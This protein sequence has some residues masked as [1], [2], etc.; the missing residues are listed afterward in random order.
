MR[1]GLHGTLASQRIDLDAL[2]L[3]AAPAATQAGPAPAPPA[4]DGRVIP[5]L[6]LPLELL[7]VTDSELHWTIGA[8]QTGGVTL[9]DTTLQAEIRDGKG[10]LDPFTTTL[11]GGRLSIR[12]AADVTTTPPS[13]QLAAQSDGIDLPTLLA[14]LH[15]P[16]GTAGRVELDLDL[17]GQGRDLRAVAATAT[18]HLGAALTNGQVE[19]GSGSL[20]GRALGDL[21]HSMPQLGGLGEGRIAVACAATRWRAEGGHRPVRGAAARWLARQGRRRRYQPTCGTRRWRCGCS[22]TCGCRSPG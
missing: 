22:S 17:R 19:S 16:G 6:P 20:L 18:G 14:A 5:D 2:A 1:Q 10:R 7:R 11:P 9:H 13:V 3:P 15:A 4:R 12:A 8:L 21:R